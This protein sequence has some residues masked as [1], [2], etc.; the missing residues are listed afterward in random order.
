MV[1]SLLSLHSKSEVLL[2]QIFS[3]VLL[4]SPAMFAATA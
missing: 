4:L 1:I 2:L 3:Y